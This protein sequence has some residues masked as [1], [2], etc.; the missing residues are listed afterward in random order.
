VDD[1]E[2]DDDSENADDSEYVDDSEYAD[3][4]EYDEEDGAEDSGEDE[5]EPV[6]P[7]VYADTLLKYSVAVLDGNTNNLYDFAAGKKVIMLN[8]WGTFCG[9]CVQEM[10][11]LGDL[12]RKYKDQ[13]FEIIGV[14]MDMLQDDGSYYDGVLDEAKDIVRDTE[15]SYPVVIAGLDLLNDLNIHAFP[16]TIFV[17]GE[18]NQISDRME[19]ARPAEDWE[20]VIRQYM[21]SD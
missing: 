5:P 4:S 9:P 11:D 13:G 18:G 3:D 16:T 20:S 21:E 6:D 15:V 10:A 14:T 17:D 2:Y 1:S 8:Y 7:A 12:E 19:G